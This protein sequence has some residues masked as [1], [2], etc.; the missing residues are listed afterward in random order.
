MFPIYEAGKNLE[1]VKIILL[2]QI[3]NIYI[4]EGNGNPFQF[5]CLG[6]PMDKGA[7]MAVVHGV[8]KSWTRLSE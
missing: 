3:N 7:W 5:S 6:N 2:L 1:L 8:A 4:G